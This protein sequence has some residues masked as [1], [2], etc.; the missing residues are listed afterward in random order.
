MPVV[1]RG[2]MVNRLHGEL[3]NQLRERHNVSDFET[4]DEG[5]D[6]RKEAD[7]PGT[8]NRSQ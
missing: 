3:S 6:P 1:N 4:E 5:Q 2:Q 8:A 7:D